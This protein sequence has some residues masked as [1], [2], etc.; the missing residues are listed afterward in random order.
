MSEAQEGNTALLDE[1]VSRLAKKLEQEPPKQTS[2]TLFL[3]R[4]FCV[5]VFG[6]LML[7]NPDYDVPWHKLDDNALWY[8][9][10]QHS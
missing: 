7:R 1:L 6:G 10:R 3:K 2:V 9:A 8:Y 5:K 4:L